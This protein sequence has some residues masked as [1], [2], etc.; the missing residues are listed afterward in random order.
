MKY[1][2]TLYSNLLVACTASEDNTKKAPFMDHIIVMK[3][4]SAMQHD[5]MHAPRTFVMRWDP[6]ISSFKVTDYEMDMQCF[7][8]DCLKGP[9]SS[10]FYYD[11]SI[12]DYKKVHVG[13]RFYMLKVGKGNTGIVMSGIITGT[14]YKDV[15][16]SG[17]GR[18][19][20]YVRI[21]P[22]CML[23]PDKAP[24]VTTQVLDEALPM[25]N[26][27]EGHSGVM[28]NE[29]QAEKFSELWEKSIT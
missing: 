4:H 24:M 19:V 12:W 23:H 2:N 21:M 22:D 9:S 8:E 7:Y 16:W 20:R 27:N 15:D 28:L 1:K 13:D 18:D 6:D 3:P 26:W 11:W 29:E 5:T 17:K 14:P 10:G 25:V